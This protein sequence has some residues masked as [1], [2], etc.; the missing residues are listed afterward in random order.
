[1]IKHIVIENYKSIRHLSLN[2]GQIN[3][4][5]GANGAGKS[6]FI[7]FFALINSILHH[8]LGN[9]T[10]D[11]GGI[12]NLLHFGRKQSAN[13]KGLINIADQTALFFD[14]RPQQ[15]SKGYIKEFG[16]YTNKM[17]DTQKAYDKWIRKVMAESVE[18]S[19]SSGWPQYRRN[20]YIKNHHAE[21]SKVPRLD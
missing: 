7:D 9:F 21:M 20:Y 14:I 19:Q 4:F 6:N 1:M 16:D 18:L 5:I 10:L 15:N 13:L 12:D 11:N 8:L 17:Q 2:L 3:I